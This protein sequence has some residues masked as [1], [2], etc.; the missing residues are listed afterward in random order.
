MRQ[1]GYPASDVFEKWLK[2]KSDRWHQEL[3]ALLDCEVGY[4]YN[5]MRD[6]FRIRCVQGRYAK[7]GSCFFPVNGKDYGDELALVEE[8]TY[9]SGNSKKQ[10]EDS[11]NFLRSIGVREVSETVYV[12]NVLKRRYAIGG[13]KPNDSDMERFVALVE[14]EPSAAGLFAD[15]HIFQI[16][17]GK[18]CKPSGIFLDKPFLATGLSA[19]YANTA[20]R[21]ALHQKYHKSDIKPD[22]LAKFA[23]AVGAQVELEIKKASCLYNPDASNL[24]HSAPGNRT[25]YEHDVDYQIEGIR[26][27]LN[28]PSIDISKLI[29][30]TLVTSNI[31]W[32]KALYRRN[33]SYPL[34]SAPSWLAHTLRAFRWVPQGN[35]PVFVK[36]INA[37][38]A[39]SNGFTFD[40]GGLGCEILNSAKTWCQL[41]I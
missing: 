41:R 20:G 39:D 21:Y 36:P 33:A 29:W 12:E 2:N 34:K 6:Y 9:T 25:G 10:Q 11:R 1:W 7:S 27:V 18:W 22:R 15:Y 14:V 31:E 37:S 23:K 16:E 3:Y 17:D 40:G 13:V 26:S 38:N 8:S 24:Y 35:E 28:Y 32:S 5:D 19:W 4:H 30:R